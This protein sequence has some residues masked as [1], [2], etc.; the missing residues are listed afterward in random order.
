MKNEDKLKYHYKKLFFDELPEQ[1]AQDVFIGG[2]AIRDYLS[3]SEVKDIDVFT[4]NKEAEEKLLAF[5]KEKGKLINENTLLANYTYKD[6]WFQVIKGKHYNT[7]YEL[8]DSFD[9][10]ICQAAL[11]VEI[12]LYPEQ[13]R[14]DL[15]V[16][17]LSADNFF[18]DTLA[19]HL[20]VHKITY[21]LSTL[22]RM[23]KYIQKGYTAC[24]GTLLEVAKSM[25][26][27]DFENKDEN[28]LVFY[29]NGGFRFFGV[30]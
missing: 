7:G 12:E 6:R 15:V 3:G 5:F 11:G 2:G 9:F 26:D 13:N 17:F 19:K 8:I 25:K 20:R 4:A 10:T 14:K 28:T 22:E 27:V 24:N 1:I 23:Q 21:P 29:P 30:D 16:H 18:Q